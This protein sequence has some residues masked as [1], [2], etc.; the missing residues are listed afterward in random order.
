MGPERAAWTGPSDQPPTPGPRQKEDPGPARGRTRQWATSIPKAAVGP[1]PPT[2]NPT[3]RGQA[4]V[5]PPEPW[6]GQQEALSR[7]ESRGQQGSPTT[8]GSA[9]PSYGKARE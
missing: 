2:P 5:L 9:L 7:E 6:K 1:C 3:R 8:G 4:T